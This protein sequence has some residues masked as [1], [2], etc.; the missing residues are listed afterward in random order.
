MVGYHCV[1]CRAVYSEARAPK[2][3][4]R[5]HGKAFAFVNDAVDP[6]TAEIERLY[7]EDARRVGVTG[8]QASPAPLMSDDAALAAAFAESE[9][10]RLNAI[11]GRPYTSAAP[12]VAPEPASVPAMRFPTNDVP[13]AAGGPPAPEQPSTPVLEGEESQS[14]SESEQS[15]PV[16]E[17]PSDDAPATPRDMPE[18]DD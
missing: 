3:C 6:E 11:A 18:R 8:L 17:E 14:W 2:R 1:G 16:L 15:T 7:R 10:F 13:P 4:D 12:P 5:C 9:R